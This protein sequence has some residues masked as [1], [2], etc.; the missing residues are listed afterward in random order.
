M[1]AANSLFELDIEGMAYGGDG[2]GHLD[3]LAVFVPLAVPGDRLRA[4]A[5]EPHR[6]YCRA[7]IEEVLRPS[8]DRTPPGCRHF[9]A[10]GGCQWQMAAYSKQ[11]HYKKIVLTEV[12]ARL[13]GLAVPDIEVLESGACWGYRNKAQL[14]VALVGGEKRIGY[15]RQGSHKLV[16]IDQCP[17]LA[18]A[19][20]KSI[21]AVTG[22]LA[23]SSFPAYD[24]SSHRGEL[25]H[26]IIR[27]CSRDGGLALT[28]VTRSAIRIGGLARELASS[29]AGVKSVYQN[30]NPQKG[31]VI[32]GPTWRT[33]WGDE[34]QWEEMS[35]LQLRLSGGSFLQVNLVAAQTLYR[36]AIDGL[37]MSGSETVLDLYSGVGSIALDIAGRAGR[38]TGIEEAAPAVEDA[39]ASAEKNGIGNCIFLC[40]R[41]EDVLREVPAAD[42]V[43]LD[44]PRQG[45]RPEVIREI[46]RLGPDRVAY[47][48]CNPSTLARDLKLFASLGYGLHRLLTADMFPHTYHIEALAMLRKERP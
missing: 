33:V 38:V 39:R 9:G 13:G 3:R 10:C 1:P 8:P 29:V 41:A 11:L 32:L 28:V 12:L 22:V 16:A 48:S 20:E 30:I 25:R 46:G 36:A 18:P 14:P 23:G 7:R 5:I 42:R 26:V 43:V 44:P 2:V 31:N 15:Y 4:R 27:H 37:E 35:G 47:L 21:Q 45:A 17:V 6:T 40:G 19:I 24:E 34:H